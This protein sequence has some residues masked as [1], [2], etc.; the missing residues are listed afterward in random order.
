VVSLK[1]NLET[2]HKHSILLMKCISTN[3]NLTKMMI[4][5]AV[6]RKK[7]LLKIKL[8]RLNNKTIVQNRIKQTN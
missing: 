4:I 8:K 3:N 5:T 1:R 7:M 2:M 6:Q